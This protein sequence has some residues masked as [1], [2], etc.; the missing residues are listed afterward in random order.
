[1]QSAA[2][3]YAALAV[4]RSLQ[5]IAAALLEPEEAQQHIVSAREL[6]LPRP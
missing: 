3:D 6:V 5:D 1:V 4:A 2:S